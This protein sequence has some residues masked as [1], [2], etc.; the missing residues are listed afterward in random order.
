MT[1]SNVNSSVVGDI[2]RWGVNSPSGRFTV[3]L[4]VSTV[5]LSI[6]AASVSGV[7]FGFGLMVAAV[8]VEEMFY[9]GLF[10]GGMGTIVASGPGVALSAFVFNEALKHFKETYN[11]AM[12]GK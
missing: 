6:L 2:V 3:A 11:L 8:A 9:F 1:S 7:V 4:I 12:D 10:F 5:A